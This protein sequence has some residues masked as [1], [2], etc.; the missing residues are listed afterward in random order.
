MERLIMGYRRT[1]SYG[2]KRGAIQSLMDGRRARS[3]SSHR[4]RGEIRELD[5]DDLIWNR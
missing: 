5:R 4:M 1:I 2:H 3:V